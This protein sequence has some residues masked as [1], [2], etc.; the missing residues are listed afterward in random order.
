[1]ALQEATLGHNNM[2][3]F[4][5]ELEALKKNASLLA[6]MYRSNQAELDK[7]KVYQGSSS[8]KVITLPEK[9]VTKLATNIEPKLG[10]KEKKSKV[11]KTSSA[12]S[13]LV[14]IPTF[15]LNNIKF[16][17]NEGRIILKGNVNNIAR[18]LDEFMSLS[19]EEISL[20]NQKFGEDIQERTNKEKHKRM[21]KIIKSRKAE[22]KT[23]IQAAERE[24]DLLRLH[25]KRL[26]RVRLKL[27]RRQKV[28]KAQAYVMTVTSDIKNKIKDFVN[29]NY[30]KI[31]ISNV[32][33]LAEKQRI[34]SIKV[35]DKLA[36]ASSKERQKLAMSNMIYAL[37]EADKLKLESQ[38]QE[39]KDLKDELTYYM[40]GIT[41]SR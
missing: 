27:A 39:I 17:F 28:S 4:A 40:E 10:K 26:E 34:K 16:K 20:M 36:E 19:E 13:K 8:S 33:K 15:L 7:N 37:K 22:Y 23:L 31:Y 38:K 30:G 14:T 24:E 18:K 6:N 25:S 1:M 32:D 41:R 21:K 11:Q 5:Q 12:K 2:D 29:Y 9:M 3:L 35:A